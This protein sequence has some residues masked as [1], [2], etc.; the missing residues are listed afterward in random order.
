M[1]L[2]ALDEFERARNDFDLAAQ[3]APGSDISYISSAHKALIEGDL[4]EVVR[5]SREGIAEHRD[6]YILLSMLGQAL[7]RSGTEPGQPE[8]SEARNALEKSIA[9]NPGYAQS[10]ISLAQVYLLENRL[11][12]AIAQLDAARALDPKNPAVYSHLAAALRRTGDKKRLQEVVAVLAALNQRQV[13]Q[14]RDAG[15]SGEHRGNI[16]SVRNQ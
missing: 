4:A 8:F 16:A 15:K 3:L 9:E 1:F 14:I 13:T 7:L 6:G 10:R 12:D 5:L 2:T 11:Q